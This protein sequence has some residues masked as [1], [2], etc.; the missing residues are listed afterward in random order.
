MAVVRTQTEMES[1]NP[2]T[3]EVMGRFPLNTQMEVDKALD[4]AREAFK[5]WRQTS[6]EERGE[7]FHRIAGHLRGNKSRYS[8]I[9]TKEMGKP[10]IESESEIEKCA[11]NCDFYAD[12]AKVFLRAC[13]EPPVRSGAA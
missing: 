2:A 9:I 11:W 10:I 13:Y 3:E 7:L 6:F 8:A 5:S 12:N 4:R 1:V